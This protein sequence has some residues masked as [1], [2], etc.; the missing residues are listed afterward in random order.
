MGHLPL[1]DSADPERTES[2]GG[3]LTNNGTSTFA[4]AL[5]IATDASINAGGGT[6]TLTGGISKNGTVATL[7]GGGIININ[8]I[9]ISGSSAN[10]D[11]VGRWTVNE[12]AANTYNG[13]TPL[14]GKRRC[15]EC[16]CRQRV[17]HLQR[18]H[19]SDDG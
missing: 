19:R 15:V 7:T 5:N 13:L 12:N 6:L 1:N 2:S 14:S 10:S 9:G 3:A 4:G 11:L 17:A 8:T 18:P 16:Q